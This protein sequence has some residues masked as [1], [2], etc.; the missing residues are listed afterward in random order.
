M[1]GGRESS[2]DDELVSSDEVMSEARRRK[3]SVDVRAGRG[4]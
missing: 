2:V 1:V 4:G 3:C